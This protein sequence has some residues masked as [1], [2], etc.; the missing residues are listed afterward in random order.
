[1]KWQ[2]KHIFRPSN[3]LLDA[4]E[5]TLVP[6]FVASSF[7]TMTR[8]RGNRIWTGFHIAPSNESDFFLQFGDYPT[9]DMI[10]EALIQATLCTKS[11]LQDPT[12]P[13]RHIYESSV[14]RLLNAFALTAQALNSFV[15]A[16]FVLPIIG[17]SHYRECYSRDIMS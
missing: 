5:L 4:V 2:W 7:S 17:K 3:A 13:L 14:G 11:I 15:W 16:N 12:K 8:N 9:E 10:D 6:S 1:M